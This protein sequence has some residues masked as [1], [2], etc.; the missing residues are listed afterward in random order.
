[1]LPDRQCRSAARLLGRA[2]RA[3]DR[4]GV[5][6]IR[7]GANPATAR[8]TPH[9]RILTPR[10]AGRSAEIQHVPQMTLFSGWA[11]PSLL[12]CAPYTVVGSGY[13]VAVSLFDDNYLF[14]PR[15]SLHAHRWRY[16]WEVLHS[17]IRSASSVLCDS[18]QATT[19][20]PFPGMEIKTHDS[21]RR[22][23]G[24]GGAYRNSSSARQRRRTA[25]PA[26]IQVQAF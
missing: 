18:S 12:L 10:S 21:V 16:N 26:Q 24:A 17:F 23:P 8:D 22:A 5:Q 4:A 19:I 3:V 13:W 11:P 1:V 6:P 25:R 2:R 9:A 14:R 20:A 7:T 15:R